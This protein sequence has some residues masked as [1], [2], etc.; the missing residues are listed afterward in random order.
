MSPISLIWTA[1]FIVMFSCASSPIQKAKINS[2]PNYLTSLNLPGQQSNPR[3]SPSGE[4]IIYVSW[5]RATHR[6]MQI[7]EFDLISQREQ[8][9]T[10]QD[11]LNQSPNYLLF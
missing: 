10:F 1:C 4:K 3:F 9:I 7:Y 2:S 8:R 11:G 5:D 6:H